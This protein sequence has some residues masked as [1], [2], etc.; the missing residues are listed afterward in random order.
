M[1]V[2]EIAIKNFP[3]ID[4]DA[5]IKEAIET[6][7]KKNVDRLLV[8]RN[9]KDLYGIITEYDI[10]FKLSQRTVK[11][12]Q[13][14]N[15]SVASAATSPVD[16]TY[17]DT[18]V[19]TAANMM[20]NRGYSSL[21][22]IDRE[23]NRLYGLVTKQEIIEIFT[24]YL[25]EYGDRGIEEVMARIQSKVE[26]FQRLVQAETKM[27]SSGFNTL[28]VTHQNYFVGL[29]SALDIARAIFTIKKLMPTQKWEFNLRRILVVD[30][31]NREVE[32]LT[33]DNSIADAVKIL[34]KGNQKLIPILNRGRVVGVVSRRHIMRFM[35]NNNLL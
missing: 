23:N 34:L 1:K 10:L 30:I 7:V 28:V 27:R 8:L 26:L 33:L 31:V 15:T 24:R 25:K 5:R 21:P 12:F 18:D 3:A 6:M 17:I 11:R 19:K 2:A 35:L 13:P 29:I 22:V 9:K 4:K 20:L 14:Y 16:I 32:T